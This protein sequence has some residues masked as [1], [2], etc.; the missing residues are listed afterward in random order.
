MKEQKEKIRNTLARYINGIYKKSDVDT[1]IKVTQNREEE[2]VLEESMDR[3]WHEVECFETTSNQNG[4]YESE[5]KLLLER[6]QLPHNR[7]TFRHFLK[8][9]AIIAVM[10]MGS[11]GVYYFALSIT[12]EEV[13]YVTVH[14]AKGK[15]QTLI[16]PDGT[17]VILNSNT[18]FKYPTHF[19]NDIRLVEMN[20]EGF[21]DVTKD[22]NKIFTI[23][24]TD[25]NIRVLGTSF[26]VKAYTE[27]EEVAVS[28]KTGKVQVDIENA[29]LKLLPNEQLV[30]ERKSKEYQK[31]NEDIEKVVVW[32]AGKLYFNKA[33]IQSV[34][35]ELQRIYDCKIEFA[36][37][38]EY[39]EYLYGEHE[40][41]SLE[42]VL[43]SIKYSTN[44][45]YKRDDNKII[46]YKD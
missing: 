26:N 20:G 12:T 27:D 21:F 30:L 35:L 36:P 39:D 45:N 34:V 11:W 16:L 1:L 5:A 2:S 3:T 46:L 13:A 22:P 43:K 4:Q 18:A 14:V 32:T 23:C 7:F 24:T 31:R 10:L 38:A 41:K 40:N 6:L 17:K 19:G 28:V 33:S 37:N 29:T 15:R 8:Y 9:A 42:S 44:I 25:A